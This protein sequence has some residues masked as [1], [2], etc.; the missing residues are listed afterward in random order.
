MGKKFSIQEMANEIMHSN[1]ILTKLSVE[2]D[3]MMDVFVQ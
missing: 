2:V 1:C 3:V